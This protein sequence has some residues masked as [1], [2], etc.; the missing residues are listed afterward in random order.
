MTAYWCRFLDRLGN[1]IGAEKMA[2]AD[3]ADAIAKTRA[4]AATGTASSYEI[5][6]DKRLVL[7]EHQAASR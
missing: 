3:D 7:R 1:A 5:W 6:D 4:I 2:A